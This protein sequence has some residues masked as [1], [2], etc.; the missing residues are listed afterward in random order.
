MKNLTIPLLLAFLLFAILTSC[1]PATAQT[2][3]KVDKV[4]KDTTISNKVY[5]LYVGAR[6]GKY[7]VA[8]SKSGKSYKR[9][10]SK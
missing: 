3:E 4:L 5:K 9:Y 6:G 10:F 7:I 1:S 2:P 8:T